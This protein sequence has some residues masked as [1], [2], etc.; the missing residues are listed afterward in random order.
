MGGWVG[1]ADL[2]RRCVSA[3]GGHVQRAAAVPVDRVD[4]LGCSVEDAEDGRDVVQHG[5]P[6]QFGGGRIRAQECFAPSAVVDAGLILRSQCG[7]VPK[8]WWTRRTGV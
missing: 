4:S 5:R 7:I 6:V 2:A 8:A 1:G 3:G